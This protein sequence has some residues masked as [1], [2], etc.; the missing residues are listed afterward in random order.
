MGWNDRVREA[1]RPHVDHELGD[2]DVM[3]GWLRLDTLVEALE[4][5]SP[6]ADACDTC[7]DPYRPTST[8]GAT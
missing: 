3:V 5:L 2:R 8:R 1:L 4:P 7:G 6:E